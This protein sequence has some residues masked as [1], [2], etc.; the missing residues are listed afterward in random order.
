MACLLLRW[1]GRADSAQELL[2]VRVGMVSRSGSRYGMELCDRWVMLLSKEL[3][4][5]PPAA[6]V[7]PDGGPFR[8]LLVGSS[9]SARVWLV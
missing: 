4:V 8:R 2:S 3:Q 1:G 5:G 7:G 9:I 6:T